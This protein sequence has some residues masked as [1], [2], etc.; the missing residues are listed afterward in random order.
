[1]PLDARDVVA[2]GGRAATGAPRWFQLYVFQDEGVTRDLV[3]R[4][5]NAG[6]TAIVLTVDTPTLGRRER[7]DLRSGVHDP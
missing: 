2:G 6:F 3:A 1:M 4:A 5:K 7:Y